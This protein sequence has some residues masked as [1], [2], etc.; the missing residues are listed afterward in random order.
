MKLAVIGSRNLQVENLGEYLPKNV[1]ELYPAVR[2][3]LTA[4]LGNTHC[5]TI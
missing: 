2:A 5:C 1:T 4:V 3:E